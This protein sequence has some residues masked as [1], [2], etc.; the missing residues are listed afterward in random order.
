MSCRVELHS[1]FS[2]YQE[3]DCDDECQGNYQNCPHSGCFIEEVRYPDG[4]L[5]LRNRHLSD[6][7]DDFLYHLGFGLQNDLAGMF[8]DVKVS[9]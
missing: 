6:V 4:S 3:D 5:K 7:K 2:H 8:G 9:Y 1:I